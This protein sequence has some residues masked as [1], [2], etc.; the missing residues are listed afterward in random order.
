MAKRKKKRGEN[1]QFL[2]CYLQ[3][4]ELAD[5]KDGM[6]KLIQGAFKI[7]MSLSPQGNVNRKTQTER[8]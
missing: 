5:N 3:R 7:A 1:N 2:V 8:G 6:M 4:K